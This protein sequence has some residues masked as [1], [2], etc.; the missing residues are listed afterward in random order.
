MIERYSK[1]EMKAVWEEKN[2]FQKWLEVELAACEANARLGKIPPESLKTIQEKA[3]FDIPRINEIERTV[4]H[5]V[6][7]FLTSVAEFVGPDSRYI[8]LGLTSSDVVDTAFGAIIKDAAKI[9]EKDLVDVVEALKNKAKENKHTVMVGRTHGIHAEPMTFGLKMAL[10]MAE[11]E[12]NLERLRAATKNVT[13]GKISGAVGT[14]ANIDPS[15]ELY[16]CEKMGLTPSPLST[17]I[18][19]RDRHA[20][21]MTTLAII[22]SSIDKFTTEIRN[23]QRTDVLEVEEPFREGQKGSSAMP[24]KRNPITCERLSGMARIMRSNAQ[25]ALENMVLWHERDIS[26]SSAERMIF[27]DSCGLLDYMLKTLA[28]VIK[29]LRVYPENMKRNMDVYGGVIFS[30]SVLLSLVNKGVTREEAYKIVQEN[31]HKAW[32]QI[33]GDF[34]GLL[35][36]DP[37]VTSLLSSEELENCFNPEHHL[38]HLDMIYKRLGLD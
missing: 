36:N 3:K 23:L 6:I 27:P 33:G 38:K 12:R 19:Q 21:F 34:R 37:R 15:V 9:L 29:D 10:W 16:V 18:I 30:Q 24:H 20:E 14:Y 35:K 17:Q 26:H 22:G 32:N 31:A 28:S 11:M 13:V 5:D 1:P 7:A 25:V 4:N 8:H 2:R